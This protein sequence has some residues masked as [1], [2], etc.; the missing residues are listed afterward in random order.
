MTVASL[1]R[2]DF[3]FQFDPGSL[4]EAFESQIYEP[5]A[6]LRWIAPVDALP[7]QLVEK[8]N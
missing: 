8:A 6:D 5:A 1:R 7:R 2:D 4:D 3:L